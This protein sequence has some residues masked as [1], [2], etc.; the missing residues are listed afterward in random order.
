MEIDRWR[1]YGYRPNVKPAINYAHP[2]NVVWK[3]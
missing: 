3:N 2:S 1:L